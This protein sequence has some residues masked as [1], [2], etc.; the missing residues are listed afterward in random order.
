MQLPKGAL[1]QI[2]TT[3]PELR[4]RI[5]IIEEH[6]TM[7]AGRQIS[8]AG[9]YKKVSVLPDMLPIPSEVINGRTVITLPEICGYLPMILE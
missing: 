9:E 3:Y 1:L 7:P 8:V 6:V 4:G 5:G 2:K